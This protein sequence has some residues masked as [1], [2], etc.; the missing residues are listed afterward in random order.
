MRANCGGLET[1]NSESTAHPT[2][3][4]CWGRCIKALACENIPTEQ[5][6]TRPPE[7][8]NL[9]MLS[10]NHNLFLCSGQSKALELDALKPVRNSRSPC[11]RRRTLNVLFVRPGFV[12][13]LSLSASK[14]TCASRELTRSQGH[15][16]SIA[17]S[18]T[19]VSC[20]RSN[21]QF[22]RELPCLRF[23]SDGVHST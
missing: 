8:V 12:E 6:P 23:L 16:Q 2:N 1:T 13:F 18:A 4:L 21:C 3:R 5:F 7:W 15:R 9:R 14:P 11:G 10:F 19:F 22:C 17:C 20:R